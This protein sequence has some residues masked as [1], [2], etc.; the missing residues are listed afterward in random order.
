MST[1]ETLLSSTPGELRLDVE[2]LIAKALNWNRAKV[3]AFGET[4]LPATTLN[5][6]REQLARLLAGE[7]YAYIV[8]QREFYG[9]N[10]RVTP[11]VLIPRPDTEL[12]V[13]LALERSPNNARVADLG[14]GSGAIAISLAHT[15]PDLRVVACDRSNSA[16][17]IARENAHQHNCEVDFVCSD[18]FDQ[19]D[20]TFDVIVSNPPY[21]HPQ[22]QHLAALSHEPQQALVAD[23]S[24]LGDLKK[25]IHGATK[26]LNPGATLLVEHGYDQATPVGAMFK[27]QG[28]SNV[29][30]HHDLSGQPRVTTGSIS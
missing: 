1:I 15:R 26:A 11:D 7:P 24:G 6:L 29:T 21:V 19:L 17:E 14:T 22:D 10:F 2:L 30:T 28:F 27:A 23:D 3:I 9:L 12:L 8:E 5:P 13:E 16:L 18:W 4:E 25:I 20:G